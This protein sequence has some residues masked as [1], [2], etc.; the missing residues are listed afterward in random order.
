VDGGQILIAALS[1]TARE[2]LRTDLATCM[3]AFAD[4]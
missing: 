4:T 1:S 3:T 2:R